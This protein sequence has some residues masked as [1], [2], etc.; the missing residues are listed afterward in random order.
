MHGAPNARQVTVE[1]VEE[2][3]DETKVR[4]WS[5]AG[6]GLKID[7][8]AARSES[9]IEFSPADMHIE[10][11][12]RPVEFCQGVTIVIGQDMIPRATLSFQLDELHV[13][14]DALVWLEA[15]VAAKEA[16]K[17]ERSEHADA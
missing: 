12:G 14:A 4:Y 5:M 9:W 2:G 16:N 15:Y 1:H 11:N 8:K 17:V 13:D 3:G 10:F 7:F 6:G